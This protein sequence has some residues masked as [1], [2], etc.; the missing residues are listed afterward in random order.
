MSEAVDSNVTASPPAAAESAAESSTASSTSGRGGRGRGRSSGRSRGGRGRGRRNSTSRT[1]A[2]TPVFLGNTDGMEGNV[3]QCHGETTNKQQFLKTVG[4]LEEHVNK[5]FTYPQDVAS[6]CKTF[7][8]VK[9]TQ[10]DNLS[11]ED[12]EGDAYGQADDLGN[13]D[14]DIHETDGH[15]R[16]Q[17]ER[18]LRN[19]LGTM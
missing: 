17:R 4:V 18:H 12:Y 1:A 11:K 14:E 8:I 3:F 15:A 13:D 9:L 19:R 16:N 6:V 5:N 2:A 7:S 10:P